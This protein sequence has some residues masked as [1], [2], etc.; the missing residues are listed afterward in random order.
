[1]ESK[2]SKSTALVT[3]LFE[4]YIDANAILVYFLCYVKNLGKFYKMV[5][6]KMETE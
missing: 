1:M 5:D 2:V 6:S 4:S 3:S